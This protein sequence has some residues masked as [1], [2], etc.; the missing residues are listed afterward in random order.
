MTVVDRLA[1]SLGRRDEAPNQE[2][3]KRI[4]EKRDKKAVKELVENLGNKNKDVQSDCI[5]VMYEIGNREP[6]L[7]TPYTDELV[8]LLGS[9]TN[10]MI[11]GAMTALDSIVLEDPETIHSEL[12][13]IIQAAEKGS[14]IARDHAVSILIK[15]VSMP[16]HT[17]E[18]F[19]LLMKQLRSCPTN[20]LPM[21]AEKA[22]PVLSGNNKAVFVRVLESRLG[23]VEQASK[24]KRIK[25]VLGKLNQSR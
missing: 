13:K 4:A 21:Y 7:I 8:A 12:P 2:L 18:A 14:V 10:R 24:R 3:A 25:K 11:W 1:T 23:Q 6:S 20:Q 5:K 17:D 16:R 19:A 9:K 22:F 15:L